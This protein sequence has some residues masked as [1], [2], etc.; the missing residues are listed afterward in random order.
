M[1]PVGGSW[2]TEL[3]PGQGS[4]SKTSRRDLISDGQDSDT[5]AQQPLETLQLPVDQTYQGWHSPFLSRLCV[6]TSYVQ[7]PVLA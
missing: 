3:T 6:A 4:S 1:G 5:S 2:Q 7:T